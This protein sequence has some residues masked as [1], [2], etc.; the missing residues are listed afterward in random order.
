MTL[1]IL[2]VIQWSN[3]SARATQTI[4]RPGSEMKQAMR[5]F[6]QYVER[7]RWT[8]YWYKDT[9]DDAY[10]EGKTISAL[11]FKTKTNR[12]PIYGLC[13][14]ELS[15]CIGNYSSPERRGIAEVK[16]DPGFAPQV[17]FDWFANTNYGDIDTS[18]PAL[19][20]ADFE[21]TAKPITLP[22]LGLPSSIRHH[23]IPARAHREANRIRKQFNCWEPGTKRPRGCTGT[24]VFAYYSE[25]DPVWYIL[26]TCSSA[27]AP[28]FRGDAIEALSYDKQGW[29]ITIGGFTN[30][31]E[32]IKW[33]KPRILKAKMF[34]FTLP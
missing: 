16:V 15:L 32:D 3:F 9:P 13:S 6:S 22:S 31:P 17:A 4:S 29:T 5:V 7:V 28:E 8:R 23:V 10:I 21:F 11:V 34:Q 20:P 24:Q 27:C 18:F 33:F 1:V 12:R 30:T 14:A 2:P 19:R 26:R 25:A